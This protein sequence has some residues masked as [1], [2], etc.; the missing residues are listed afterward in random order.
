MHYVR[1]FNQKQHAYYISAV[2]GR[3]DAYRRPIPLILFDP[4]ED[5]FI[6]HGTPRTGTTNPNRKC[7]PQEVVL[8]RQAFFIQL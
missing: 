3:C 8:L 5:A 2:Y 7:L 1:A 6:L 4:Y